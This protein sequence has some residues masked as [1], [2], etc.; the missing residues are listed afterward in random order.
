[1]NTLNNANP[2]KNPPRSELTGRYSAKASTTPSRVG[3]FYHQDIALQSLLKAWRFAA[4][5]GD[6]DMILLTKLKRSVAP[7]MEKA[8]LEGLDHGAMLLRI[9]TNT[10]FRWAA[11]TGSQMATVA[12]TVSGYAL[13]TLWFHVNHHQRYIKSRE[14]WNMREDIDNA[15]YEHL[16]RWGGFWDEVV[17]QPD[18]VMPPLSQTSI[19]LPRKLQ[20]QMMGKQMHKK[21]NEGISSIV[22]ILRRTEMGAIPIED[23]KGNHIAENVYN[24]AENLFKVSTLPHILYLDLT[25]TLRSWQSL[26]CVHRACTLTLPGIEWPSFRIEVGT[27]C[28]R[29]SKSQPISKRPRRPT[30]GHTMNPWMW[31]L[32][33]TPIFLGRDLSNSGIR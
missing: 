12:K 27:I 5:S 18:D 13:N 26:Q 15:F 3:L 8:S 22:R 2:P 17:D 7:S 9:V 32:S 11:C 30:Q 4:V 31:T 19:S 24:A 16:R 33:T 25:I 1:M 29:L 28:L 20:L 6:P 14:V 23:E 10:G 21:V